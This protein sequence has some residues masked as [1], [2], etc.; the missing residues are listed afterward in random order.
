[1]PTP[2]AAGCLHGSYGG[3]KSHLAAAIAHHLVAAGWSVRY[4]TVPGIL[5]AD[6]G[7]LQDDGTAD[8]VFADLLTRDLLV[9]DDLDASASA[10]TTTSGCSG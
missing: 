7:G 9:L 3:G 6:Q 10:A 1:M 2:C 4:R 8:A 5:D